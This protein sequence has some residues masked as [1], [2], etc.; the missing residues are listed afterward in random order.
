MYKIDELGSR[1]VKI[2]SFSYM[3]LYEAKK[4]LTL[5]IRS[6]LFLVSVNYFALL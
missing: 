5:C 3:V 6:T 2:L 1:L 4:E